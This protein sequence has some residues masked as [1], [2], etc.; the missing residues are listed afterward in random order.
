M[1]DFT[2]VANLA[3]LA[4]DAGYQKQGIGEQLIQKAKRRQGRE[5]MIVL[6][7]APKTNGYYPKLAFEHNPW[8]WL[9]KGG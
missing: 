1:A 4:V 3:D 2:Y 6:L 5:C 7:A 8:A 9:L